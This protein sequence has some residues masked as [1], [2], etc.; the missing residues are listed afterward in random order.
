MAPRIYP[1]TPKTVLLDGLPDGR[2]R[3]QEIATEQGRQALSPE[4]ATRALQSPLAA[5]LT[6]SC[7]Q[8]WSKRAPE[9][10]IH[11]EG[12]ATDANRLEPRRSL[13]QQ[14]QADGRAVFPWPAYIT[15]TLRIEIV[16]L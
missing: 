1:G 13:R 2:R 16:K 6:P 10:E 5:L 11:V 4:A 15:Q 14:G 7:S 12:G 3:A 9:A 8:L